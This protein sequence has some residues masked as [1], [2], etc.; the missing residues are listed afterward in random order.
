MGCP[1]RLW[2]ARAV[3][4]PAGLTLTP[5][6]GLAPSDAAGAQVGLELEFR[7]GK[8]ALVSVRATVTQRLHPVYW[9]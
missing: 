6:L 5:C 4:A 1:S 8:L 7:R 3:P 9:L 2:P